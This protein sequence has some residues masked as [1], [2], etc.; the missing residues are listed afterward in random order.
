MRVFL[1]GGSGWIGSHLLPVLLKRGHTVA[2]LSRSDESDA[3]IKAISAD[4]STIEIVK[5]GIADLDVLGAAAAKADAVIHLGFIHDFSNFADSIVKDLAAIKAM[6]APLEGTGKT[7]IGTGGVAI[8]FDGRTAVETDRQGDQMRGGAENYVLSLADK[9]VRAM[10]CRLANSVHGDGDKGFV[11]H[12]IA[13]SKRIGYAPYAPG[14]SWVACHVDDVAE[15]Y[16]LALEKGEAGKIY[17]GAGKGGEGGVSGKEISGLV[18]KTLG[19]ELKENTSEELQ[20]EMGLIGMLYSLPLN[21]TSNIT[22]KELGWN[23]E[24]PTLLEDMA[25]YYFK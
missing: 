7:F 12:V 2:A 1:T 17:H 6:T 16:A 13:T 21:G 20:K 11:P 3:K 5:G 18:A 22:Q 19:L 9:G 8:H 15:L 23:P 24:C 4:E 25:A 10:T 14:G